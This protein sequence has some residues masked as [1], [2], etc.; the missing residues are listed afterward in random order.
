MFVF[1]CFSSIFSLF[2]SPLFLL[3]LSSLIFLFYLL[4]SR[5]LPSAPPPPHVATWM[6]HLTFSVH[7]SN[8]ARVCPVFKPC[9]Y[10]LNVST[11]YNRVFSTVRN[12][13]GK[14]THGGGRS[15]AEA[16]ADEEAQADEYI[17]IAR[18]TAP[19]RPYW[20]VPCREDRRRR[21]GMNCSSLMSGRIGEKGVECHLVVDLQVHCSYSK[22][23][24]GLS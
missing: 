3:P 14:G 22:Y 16:A 21:R 4:F 10:Q 23:H 2:F 8:T 6:Q 19:H 15:V 12:V 9:T 24:A 13:V 11:M 17:G 18:Y 1:L 20:T 7:K 5:H